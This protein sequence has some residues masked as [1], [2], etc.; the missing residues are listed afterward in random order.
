MQPPDLEDSQSPSNIILDI[1]QTSALLLCIKLSLAKYKM[2]ERL[3][4][5]VHIYACQLLKI[6][7]LRL[8]YNHIE[9]YKASRG[10]HGS[11]IVRSALQPLNAKYLL[12]LAFSFKIKFTY[13]YFLQ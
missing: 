4:H 12:T 1:S 5:K 6:F 13:T 9:S 2:S 7:Q 3:S 11:I 10:A 8:N